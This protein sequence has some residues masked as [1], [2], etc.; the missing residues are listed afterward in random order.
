MLTALLLG[1]PGTNLY[2]VIPNMTS[3]AESSR[4][5]KYI[6]N[7]IPLIKK[8]DLFQDQAM[9]PSKKHV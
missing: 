2:N 5:V 7:S 8:Q 1:M 3:E 9:I 4:S 6:V